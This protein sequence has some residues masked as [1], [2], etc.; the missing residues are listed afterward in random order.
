VSVTVSF[1]YSIFL[2]ALLVFF[3]N[4]QGAKLLVLALVPPRYKFFITQKT[5]AL[6]SSLIQVPVPDG[7]SGSISIVRVIR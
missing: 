4:T 6:S 5:K 3:N 7:S 2:I 1:G